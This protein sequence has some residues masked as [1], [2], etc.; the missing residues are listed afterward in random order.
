MKVSIIILSYNTEKLLE[1][2]LASIE[3]HIE[4]PHEIIVVDNASTDTSVPMLKKKFSQVKVIENQQ[5]LGFAKG[6]N[7]GAGEA[8]G[9]YL[10]FLNSD[11]ELFQDV[12]SQLV[13]VME[14]DNTI[15]VVGGVLKNRDGSLQRSF[16]KF[17]DLMPAALLIFGGDKVE[18]LGY[19]E[20]DRDV[21]W[22]SGGCM[23]VRADVFRQAQ[24]FDES[25]FMYLEDMD[26]CKRIHDLGYRVVIVPS[27]SVMHIG[28]GSSNRSFAIINIYKGLDLYYKKN[29]GTVQQ[30]TLRLLL[31]SKAAL[32]ISIG[33][34]TGKKDLVMT[35]K[36]ALKSL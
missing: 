30:L 20:K 4:I 15:G 6:V 2:C 29:K 25:Y 8:K 27:A 21:D 28:Q 26:L 34:L 11:A 22:V 31:R 10:W 12:A 24:G 1:L 7:Q 23:M 9:E 13:R 17:Y 33:V 19:T 5:N 18:L 32:A 14:S 3:K 36:N 35:Y 16:S